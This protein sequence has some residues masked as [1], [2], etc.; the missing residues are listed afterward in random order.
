MLTDFGKILKKLMVDEGITQGQLAKD[1][2]ISPAMLSNYMTGKNIP[3]MKFV[4]RCIERFHLQ[5]GALRGIFT[6]SFSS[7]AR[8]NN[9]IVLDTRYFEEERVNL[10]V[11]A[12]TILLLSRPALSMRYDSIFIDLEKNIKNF[13]TNMDYQEIKFKPV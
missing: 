4:R 2:G 9:K 5:A 11:Q 12:I 6:A 1:I 3:E 7:T 8:A 13:Y 10:L